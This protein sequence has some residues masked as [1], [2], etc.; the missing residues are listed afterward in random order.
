MASDI[1]QFIEQT[2]RRLGARY[3][4]NH[5][6]ARSNLYADESSVKTYL[7]TYFPRTVFEFQTIAGEMLD[8]PKIR[9]SLNKERPLRVLDVGSG[10]GGAWIGLAMALNRAQVSAGL[11]VEALDG[12]ALALS[13]QKSFAQAITAATGMSI[14]L[15]THQ[16]TLG[17]TRGAFAA[18]LSTAL[19]ALAGKFDVVLVSKHLSDVAAD[20]KL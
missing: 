3:A 12:N 6:A 17:T 9:R 20:L 1:P 7:G 5:D 14:D 16:V 2:A 18:D 8:H 10:T 4:P 11:S 13:V 15:N 19:S